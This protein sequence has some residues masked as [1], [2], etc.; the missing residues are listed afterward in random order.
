MAQ[1]TAAI[2]VS[3]F[4]VEVSIDG[5][6]W[7]DIS[8]QAAAVTVDGGDIPVGE[9]MTAEGS[10][11]IVVSSGKMEPR[12]VTVRA[13]YTEES[14]E[15][16]ETVYARYAGADKTIYLRWS[17]KGGAVGDVRYTC[18]VAGAAAAVPVVSCSIPELDAGS[19]ELA[20]F[21]FAVKTPGLLKAEVA[22]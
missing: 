9:Q 11:A 10:E 7:T 21:E 18:A 5:S 4:K 22:S 6:S 17:P 8:G 12:N 1:T 19:E 3:G 15:A 13:V 16:F 14:G 20:L 2:A